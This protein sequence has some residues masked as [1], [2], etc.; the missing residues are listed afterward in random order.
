MN[1]RDET[2]MMATVSTYERLRNGYLEARLHLAGELGL[3]LLLRQGMLAWTRTRPMT[4]GTPPPA[5]AAL[6]RT[7]V[8][9]PLHEEIVHVMVTMTTCLSRSVHGGASPA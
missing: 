4:P 2:C 5:P 7:R 9:V 8:P 1:S 3:N 6:D